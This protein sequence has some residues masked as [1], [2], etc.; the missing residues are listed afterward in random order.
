MYIIEIIQCQNDS[1][2]YLS[3]N[4]NIFYGVQFN[5]FNT[6]MSSVYVY[7]IST[8]TLRAKNLAK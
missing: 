8:K 7:N 1:R 2:T 5:I 6:N 3:N 4:C